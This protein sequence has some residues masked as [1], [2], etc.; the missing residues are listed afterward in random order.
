M[1]RALFYPVLLLLCCFLVVSPARGQSIWEWQNPLPQGN[2]LYDIDVFGT[3]TAVACGDRATIIRTIDG[4][5]TWNVTSLA[6]GAT[7][8]LNGICIIDLTTIVAVGDNGRI[9]RSTDGGAS[10]TLPVSG[11]SGHLFGV[12]FH[13][14]SFG[15]AVGQQGTVLTSSD[16]G[17]TWSVGT[18][19]T[20]SNLY[21]ICLVNANTGTAVG[22]GG[23]V[24]RTT[25][26]GINWTPQA[27]GVAQRLKGVHFI[28][29][30]T[31][32]VVGSGPV[33]IGTTNGGTSW[34]PQTMPSF[35][36]G[37]YSDLESVWMANANDIVAVGA[38][39]TDYSVKYGLLMRS[40]NGGATW[41]SNNWGDFLYGTA[42]FG[43]DDGF[44]VGAAGTIREVTAGLSWPRA[45][46]G[47]KKFL[48]R[49]VDFSSSLR[50]AAVV[51]DNP[52]SLSGGTTRLYYTSDGGATWNYREIIEH[53]F[54]DIAFADALTVYAVGHGWPA[55]DQGSS[56][57]KSDDGGERWGGFYETYC[58]PDGSGCD[59]YFA[60]ANAVDFAGHSRRHCDDLQRFSV[61][62]LL[63]HRRN[64]ERR[65]G[66]IFGSGICSW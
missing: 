52:V 32:I 66:S 26:A 59:Y 15:V 22:S 30:N 27:S 29:A 61:P 44:A 65:I 34:T 39:E 48:A 60:M 38:F 1:S 56:I 49:A 5:G 64:T 12:D 8:D 25:D 20:F 53:H 13:A 41:D 46:G 55:M 43:L 11:V 18:S 47:Q 51:S 31:G 10:W 17:A 63:P 37:F 2:T 4:G 21:G 40:S 35:P 6:G 28:D 7:E 23:A 3:S 33:A 42:L 58:A 9:L 62:C 16:A 57:W 45:G 50:G 24:L 36:P 19:G 14:S 54:V